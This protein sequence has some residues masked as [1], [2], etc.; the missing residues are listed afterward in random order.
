MRNRVVTAMAKIKEN[1]GIK[2]LQ[3]CP[4]VRERHKK[5]AELLPEISEWGI[6]IAKQQLI[7]HVHYV[8]NID[9]G[10]CEHF[11]LDDYRQYCRFDGE[12]NE[13]SCLIPQSFCIFRDQDGKPKYPEFV[14]CLSSLIQ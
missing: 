14:P 10:V 6:L 3:E 2:A 9:L 1:G 4:T 11:L 7:Y 13:C 8:F 12:K 5:L